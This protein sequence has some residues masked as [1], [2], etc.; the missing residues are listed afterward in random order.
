MFNL[1]NKCVVLTGG[2]G[3]L[4]LT[5]TC[6]L[7]E[8]GANVAV[9]D[10]IPPQD[11]FQKLNAHLEPSKSSKNIVYYQCD[12]TSGENVKSTCQQVCSDFQGI[13][14]LINNASLVKQVGKD[15]LS[16]AYK[17]FLQMDQDDWEQYLKVDVS[18][19]ILMAQQLIPKMIEEGGGSIINISSTYGILSPDQRIYETLL[20]IVEDPSKVAAIEKPIG[21]SVS[22]SAVLNLTRYLATMYGSF[23]IRVNTLTPGGVFADNPKAFVEAYSSKTP[24]K[25]MAKK[26][27]YVGPII[28]L[29]SDASSYMTGANLVVDG[30]WSA[31]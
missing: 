28:F 29:A 6:G 27:E 19:A 9:L 11:Y 1:Q 18:G 15:D 22:K 13:H 31:W 25:R 17:P 30:G 20:P 3:L 24:L 23:G 5:Y 16:D 8:S 12:I 7:V 21:Y 2:A 4:G 14:V 26:E 10:R